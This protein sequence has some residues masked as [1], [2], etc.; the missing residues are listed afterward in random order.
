MHCYFAKQPLH[1]FLLLRNNVAPIFSNWGTTAPDF[2]K[3]RPIS[4]KERKTTL[5]TSPHFQNLIIDSR[6][7]RWS[8]ILHAINTKQVYEDI[9]DIDNICSNRGDTRTSYLNI[10]QPINICS[11]SQIF[12]SQSN[13][14]CPFLSQNATPCSA[15]PGFREN[16]IYCSSS[17]HAYGPMHINWKNID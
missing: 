11:R 16:V 17:T 3:M 10:L 5:Q 1:S 4:H 2:I 14:H 8:H 12:S 9:E 6:L 13:L 15:P 7:S